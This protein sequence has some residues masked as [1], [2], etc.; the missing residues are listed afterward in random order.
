MKIKKGK[1]NIQNRLRSDRDKSVAETKLQTTE[2]DGD[3][4]EG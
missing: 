3:L 4:E 2:V 1:K